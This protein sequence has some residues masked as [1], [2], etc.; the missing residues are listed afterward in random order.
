MDGSSCGCWFPR[1]RSRQTVFASSTDLGSAPV[2]GRLATSGRDTRRCGT[3]AKT[4]QIRGRSTATPP[5]TAATSPTEKKTAFPVGTWCPGLSVE[6]HGL[7]RT[8]SC[9]SPVRS[10]LS[11]TSAID[12]RWKRGCS[13]RSC[14][15]LRTARLSARL[16]RTNLWVRATSPIPSFVR[17]GRCTMARCFARRRPRARAG[18]A[19]GCGTTRPRRSSAVAV[20]ARFERR[21]TSTESRSPRK[22]IR[23][24]SRRRTRPTSGSEAI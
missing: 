1:S 23:T 9:K 3:W 22:S 18:R 10:G 20:R 15:R 7:P 6:L 17:A 5:G 11:R 16:E 2:R 13:T 4:P 24:W 19:A 14:R 8:E 12:S 21:S